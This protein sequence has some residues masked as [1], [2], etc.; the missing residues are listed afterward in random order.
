MTTIIKASGSRKEPAC[1]NC[2]CKSEDKLFEV[3]G[4]LELY[5]DKRVVVDFYNKHFCSQSC[6]N[7]WL[8]K[9]LGLAFERTTKG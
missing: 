4:E 8:Q 5:L 7:R 6:I 1:F 3:A 2:G 9:S